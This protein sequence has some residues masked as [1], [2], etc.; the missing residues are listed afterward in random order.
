MI[1]KVPNTKPCISERDIFLCMRLTEHGYKGTYRALRKT[2]RGKTIRLETVSACEKSGPVI[3]RLPG[4]DR[5][6]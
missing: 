4:M 1:E 3:G 2:D 6:A 5:S